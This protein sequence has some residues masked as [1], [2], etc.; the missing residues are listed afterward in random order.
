MRYASGP[1]QLSIFENVLT[2]LLA[3]EKRAV[4]SGVYIADHSQT[5]GP[6]N[7]V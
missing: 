4:S 2:R 6:T 1:L 5:L 3:D 7:N